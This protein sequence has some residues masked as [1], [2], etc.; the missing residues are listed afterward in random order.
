MSWVRIDDKA[1]CHQKFAGV[2]GNAVRLWMF[3]LCWCN[4][5]ETDG[6]VPRSML[7]VLGGTA[8]EADELVTTCLW[9][10]SAHGFVVHDY[11][12]Y[13]I[14]ADELGKKRE[15]TKDRVK[16][17]RKRECNAVT[18]A[19]VTHLYNSPNPNPNPNPKKIPESGTKAPP[20]PRAVVRRLRRC[21]DGFEPD[22]TAVRIAGELRVSLAVELPKFRDWEFKDPKSDWQ[23][24][25]RTWIR[26]AAEAP[27]GTFQTG[28][29]YDPPVA[30]RVKPTAEAIA[31]HRSR[32]AA[33]IARARAQM[34]PNQ[35]ETHTRATELTLVPPNASNGH[36]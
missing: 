18:G 34:A 3:A 14:S 24:T 21:P 1:W 31:E 36:L 16:T 30:P 26:K 29:R 19:V 33:L 8:K 9:A 15:A 7:R 25:L 11:L 23:A 10:E 32:E 2:S 20:T 12:D 35:P 5:H 17:H 28:R 4:Q 22:A 13:Q 27:S 6:Q